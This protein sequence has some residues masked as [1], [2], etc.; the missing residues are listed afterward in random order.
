MNPFQVNRR[1]ELRYFR[2]LLGIVRRYAEE[3]A[4]W[5]SAT[6]LTVPEW[7]EAYAN[8]AARRMV[9]GLYAENARSWRQAAYLSSE[10]PAIRLA[11]QRELRSRVGRRYRELI[12]ENAALIKSLPEEAA[13]VAVQRAARVAR[14]GRRAEGLS[15]EGL[16]RHVARSRAMLIART[17]TAKANAALTQARAEDLGLDWYVWQ[18]SEDQRVRP[19][20]RK[21]QGVLVRFNEPPSPEALIG[22]RSTLGHYGAGNCPNCRCYSEPLL[23]TS[24]I[25]WPHRA[26]SGGR[27]QM[28]TLAQFR[29]MNRFTEQSAA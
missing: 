25:A 6:L 7:L 18:T 17:E 13:A 27:L 16:F 28:V 3:F 14:E 20:H 19:S 9:T 29:I 12:R 11:L 10:G 5:T 15:G 26:Y 1:T 2:D 21:M 22:Q 4:E 23:R 8:S 24:Q